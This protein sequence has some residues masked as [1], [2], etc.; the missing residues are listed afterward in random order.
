VRREVVHEGDRAFVQSIDAARIGQAV[1]ELGGGRKEKDDVLDLGV[2]IVLGV[3][4]GS[5][6]VNRTTLY[7]IYARS[8]EDAISVEDNLRGSF[9]L[10]REPIATPDLILANY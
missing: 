6:V 4:V 9:K 5:E 2:G 3:T 7:T 1:I 8:Q 10:V